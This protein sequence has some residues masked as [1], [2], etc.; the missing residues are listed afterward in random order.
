M[1]QDLKTICGLLRSRK[2]EFAVWLRY[3]R[4]ERWSGGVGSTYGSREEQFASYIILNVLFGLRDKSGK[5]YSYYEL[6]DQDRET[7]RRE[8]LM[9]KNSEFGR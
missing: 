4:E 5:N 8:L 3:W 7:V 2:R 6:S 1:A 9:V